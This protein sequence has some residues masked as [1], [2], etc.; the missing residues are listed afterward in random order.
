MKYNTVGASET[1]LVLE[2]ILIINIHNFPQ[3]LYFYFSEISDLGSHLDCGDQFI[4]YINVQD[5]TS[6]WF[7]HVYRKC[8]QQATGSDVTQCM[9]TCQGSADIKDV[10]LLAPPG[11]VVG[12][13][14]RINKVTIKLQ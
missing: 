12:K 13:N 14:S 11:G 1:I 4:M 8:R 6:P 9:F 5:Y 10:F 3:I 2:S 7:K